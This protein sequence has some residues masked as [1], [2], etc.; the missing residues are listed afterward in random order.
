MALRT[1]ESCPRECFFQSLDIGAAKHSLSGVRGDPDHPTAKA[2]IPLP[3]EILD[4][5]KFRHRWMVGS[6]GG[7][8]IRPAKIDKA[9]PRTRNL[10]VA[11]R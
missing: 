4:F 5:S 1:K 7:I 11:K 9:E 8:L 10:K 2:G 3:A 6:A